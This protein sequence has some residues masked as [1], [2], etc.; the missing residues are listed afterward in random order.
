M[1]EPSE[2]KSQSSHD[3]IEKIFK[4]NVKDY[5]KYTIAYGYYMKTGIFAQKMSS[6]VVGF[7]SET[8]EIVVIPI[9]SKGDILENPLFL[10]KENIISAKFG[11]QGN[12]KIKSTL[13]KGEL[14][15]YVPAHTPSSLQG[16]YILPIKQMDAAVE[17]RNFI[18]EN[19]K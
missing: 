13:L 2:D 18:K 15:F 4:E 7:S 14:A 3:M 8:K 6:Y 19:F 10:N 16:A 17:F 1:F 5:D 9:T 12:V 11:L